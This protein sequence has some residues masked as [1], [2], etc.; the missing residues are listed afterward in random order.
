MI[1]TIDP[2]LP[3][4]RNADGRIGNAI[5]LSGNGAYALTYNT[6]GLDSGTLW[7]LEKGIRCYT[8]EGTQQMSAAVSED[9]T[10]VYALID[11]DLH[12]LAG[13]KKEG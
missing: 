12:Y 7:D 8:F 4:T 5:A 9:G 10:M 11:D 6:R 13:A 2:E 1:R 3:E